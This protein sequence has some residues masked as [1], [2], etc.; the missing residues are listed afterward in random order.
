MEN[1]TSKPDYFKMIIVDDEP[2]IRKGFSK[3]LKWNRI[4]INVVGQA[5]NGICAIELAKRVKP[6]I[7]VTDIRMPEM[8]GLELIR[9]LKDMLVDSEFI[10]PSLL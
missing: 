7:V 2:L 5:E 1:Q 6:D 8:D 3:Y 10:Y 9:L 4:G